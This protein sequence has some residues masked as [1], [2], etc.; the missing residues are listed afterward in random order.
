MSRRL[1]DWLR[2]GNGL[3]YVWVAFAI[4]NLA[5]MWLLIDFDGAP[6]WQTVPLHFV[7][8]SFTILYGFRLWKT[9]R[10][11][12][13]IVFVSVTTGGMTLVA[14]MAGHEGWPEETEVPLMSL[15]FLAMVFHAQRRVQ[16]MA[17]AESLAKE[18]A[19]ICC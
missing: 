8:V 6:G 10:T 7:Y 2:D 16:A 4:L 1:G 11:V 5:A 14:I 12:L 9:S 18:N 17:V 13:G 19:A 15:M 3:E